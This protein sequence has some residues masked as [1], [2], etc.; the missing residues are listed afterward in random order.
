MLNPTIPLDGWWSINSSWVVEHV[1]KWRFFFKILNKVS[2]CSPP[3]RHRTPLTS[4]A[5][6][7]ECSL[8]DFVEELKVTKYRMAVP[9]YSLSFCKSDVSWNIIINNII[10]KIWQYKY[11]KLFYCIE[12]NVILLYYL[13][14]LTII[15]IRFRVGSHCYDFLLRIH[16]TPFLNCCCGSNSTSSLSL[17]ILYKSVAQWSASWHH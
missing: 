12:L 1:Y 16:T 5:A 17:P 4:G 13:S 9:F 15:W 2:S 10:I 7:V 6:S 11:F 8:P 3:Q 14:L